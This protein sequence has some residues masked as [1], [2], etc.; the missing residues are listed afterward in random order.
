[1][2]GRGFARVVKKSKHDGKKRF[3]KKYLYESDYSDL[4]VGKI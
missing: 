1:L 3:K 4:C 2:R